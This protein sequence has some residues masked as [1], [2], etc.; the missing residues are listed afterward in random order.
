MNK[1]NTQNYNT[2][3][4]NLSNFKDFTQN[5]DQEKEDL[6]K[7]SNSFQKND[8]DTYELPNIQKMKYNRVTRKLDTESKP[9]ID[10][11]LDSIESEKEEA[12]K[13]KIIDE[14]MKHLRKF[15][16][17][18]PIQIEEISS[19]KRDEDI[20]YMFPKNIELMQSMV[21]EI[22]E[23]SESEIDNLL[24]DGHNWAEDH[25]SMAKEAISHVRNFLTIELD[26]VE[27]SENHSGNYM[28]FAN[29]KSIHEMCEEINKLDWQDIDNL[30]NDGHDWA[31]DHISAAKENVQQVYDF[32]KTS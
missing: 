15:E 29:L 9:Q 28:F 27:M 13:L 18:E 32:I 20:S 31:E 26:G 30:L 3:F 2:K 7:I 6:K 24:Q 14:N 25:I 8:N 5:V 19:E 1:P 10:D 22:L 12:K 17:F 11:R 21:G 23:M 16:N 4:S